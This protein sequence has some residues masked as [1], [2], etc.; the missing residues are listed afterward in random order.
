MST[1]GL[2]TAGVLERK[3]LVRGGQHIEKKSISSTRAAKTDLASES[4][5]RGSFLLM[6]RL[7]ASYKK[8]L[9]FSLLCR[10][11]KTFFKFILLYRNPYSDIN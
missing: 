5:S 11:M 1:G 7:E 4:S 6:D 10:E 3:Q 8:L 2:S 9:I